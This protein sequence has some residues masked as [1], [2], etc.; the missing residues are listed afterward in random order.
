[1]FFHKQVP[2]NR[3]LRLGSTS[4]DEQVL[5]AY[6]DQS[7]ALIVGI[8]DYG[9]QHPQLAN[10]RNDAVA[11]ATMLKKTYQFEHVIT[12]Y[13][14]AASYPALLTW[15]RDKLP[16]QVGPNDRFVFFFAGHGT[17]R[18]SSAGHQRGYIIP[19][20]AQSG[21][22][23]NYVDMA[24]LRDA[25]GWIPAKHIFLILDCCF[26]GIAA[27]AARSTSQA[28]PLQLSDTYL[29]RIT[30]QSAWQVLTAGA[31]DELAADSGVRAGHS[32]FTGALISALEGLADQNE[33]GIITATELANYVRPEVTRSSA[34]ASGAGQTPFFSYLAGSGQ[35]DFVFL[36]PGQPIRLSTNKPIWPQAGQEFKTPLWLWAVLSM[37]VLILIVGSWVALRNNIFDS[38]SIPSKGSLEVKMDSSSSTEAGSEFGEDS[39]QPKAQA[40]AGETWLNPI[41]NAIYVFVSPGRFFMGSSDAQIEVALEL[42][43][44]HWDDCR[45]DWVKHERGQAELNLS[46]FWIS[47]TEVTNSQF[48]KFIDAQGYT[49]R[50]YWSADGWAWLQSEGVTEPKF[51]HDSKYNKDT[52]PVVG[53]SWFEA[54]AYAQWVSSETNSTFRLPTEAEWEKAARGTQGNIFPWGNTWEGTQVNYCDEMCN[55][56]DATWRD[57]NFNDEYA[58]TAPVDEFLSGRSP[59]GALN[60]AG[61]VWEWTNSLFRRYPYRSDDGREI[62]DMSSLRA[63]RGGGWGDIAYW[64]RTTFRGMNGG[65]A[66]NVRSEFLGFRIVA[67][68]TSTE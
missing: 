54:E 2:A 48:Q 61:N 60:M 13:D 19:Q 45:E 51:W 65:T 8:N 22:Y 20:D 28:M 7:W 5:Q 33:D 64:T 37:F 38:L 62:M 31:S 17:T 9:G 11:M 47:R 16:N 15:L 63:T 29:K 32:A 12:L 40:Q 55:L 10:A 26:S 46:G 3:N 30:E 25:C 52:Y 34:I 53:I 21:Q 50:D 43:N 6:Y 67:P 66:P 68:V 1:M 57:I 18:K 44:Q 23:A 49:T 41:D 27:V 14:E 35:G 42:C 39:I 59:Y 36:R 58:R 4:Q 56:P 24:E